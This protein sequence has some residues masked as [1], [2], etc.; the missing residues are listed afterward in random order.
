MTLVLRP[1]SLSAFRRPVFAAW[2]KLLSF[3]P[4][5]SVTSP[6][7]IGFAVGAAVGAAVW[8]A[9]GEAEV[10][11]VFPPPH[12]ATTVVANTRYARTRFMSYPLFVSR[13][14]RKRRIARRPDSSALGRF[15]DRPSLVGLR[16]CPH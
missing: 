8:A 7:W 4:P 12:A 15:A 6:T 2:L 16:L 3:S 14:C 13:A 1:K 10:P 11:A 5:T 9:V